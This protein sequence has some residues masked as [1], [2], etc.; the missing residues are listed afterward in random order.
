M[1]SEPWDWPEEPRQRRRP[2]LEIPPSERPEHIRVTITTEQ[3]RSG[4]PRLLIIG[5]LVFLAFR[6]LPYLGIGLII[7]VALAFAYQ[8]AG[9]AFAAWLV[10][11]IAIVVWDRRRRRIAIANDPF[12]Q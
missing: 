10:A 7:I 1:R 6:F 9:I 8:V 4:V 12:V 2:R 11:S 3:R 5:A